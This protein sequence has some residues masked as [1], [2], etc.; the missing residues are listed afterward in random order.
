MI[1]ADIFHQLFFVQISTFGIID[2]FFAM[3]IPFL[4]N[5][6]VISAFRYSFPISH[7]HKLLMVPLIFLSCLTAFVMLLLHYNLAL[8][9]GLVGALSIVRFRT[10]I[11]TGFELCL[12]LL[13]IAIGLSTGIKQYDVTLIAGLSLSVIIF[14][15][16]RLQKRL[17]TTQSV[18]C[19][20]TS[21]NSEFLS[22]LRSLLKTVNLKA[23]ILSCSERPLESEHK[24][25]VKIYSHEGVSF[26]ELISKLRKYGI[27]LKILGH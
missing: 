5:V 2:L 23:S 12:I 8:G 19:E 17:N 18:L 22:Q 14:F 4:C 3:T 15:L 6:A 25:L 21:Q 24:A 7:R 9:F 27:T 1:F 10:S 11:Q 16:G 13:A 20:T 26:E